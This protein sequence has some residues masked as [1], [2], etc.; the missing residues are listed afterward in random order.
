[1]HRRGKYRFRNW[2]NHSIVGGVNE[3]GIY[4]RFLETIHMKKCRLQQVISTFAR[5]VL[6]MVLV[7]TLPA[8]L[9]SCSSAGKENRHR[10]MQLKLGM[11]REQV[12]NI[13]GMPHINEA[14]KTD[15]GKAR[16]TFFYPTGSMIPTNQLTALVFEDGKLIKWS[17]DI[18]PKPNEPPAQ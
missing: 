1:L 4:P 6:K 10:L 12:M 15:D 8:A 2:F 16:E 3:F 13:M 9:V 11:D 7:L 18:K 14:A 5:K 17:R